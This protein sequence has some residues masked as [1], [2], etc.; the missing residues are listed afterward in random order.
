MDVNS[1]L[2]LI[3]RRFNSLR[4]SEKKV[5]ELVQTNFEQVIMLSLQGLAEECS[6]SDA[7][8]LRFCRSLGYRGC[9]DFKAALVPDLLRQGYRMHRVVEPAN[10][11]ETIVESCTSSEPFG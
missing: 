10:G 3:N 2:D 6:V 5:A 8:V 7:T 9:Q 11:V 4:N 1:P